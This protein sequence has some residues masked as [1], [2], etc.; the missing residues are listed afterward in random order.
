MTGKL[1]RLGIYIT[2]LNHGK[3]SATKTRRHKK[4]I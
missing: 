2:Y 1:G 3:S 4:G